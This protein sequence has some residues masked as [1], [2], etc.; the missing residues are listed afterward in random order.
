M[1]NRMASDAEV[2]WFGH[3]GD[4]NVHLNIL[5]PIDQPIESFKTACEPLGDAIMGVVQQFGGSVSAEHGVGLLK[6]RYLQYTRSSDEI[7][8]IKVLKQ[9]LDPLGV[10]NPG[11]I[12]DL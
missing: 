11:K 1:V 9:A 6:K 12:L 3:I 10:M 8:Q 5:K 2:I 4:G 7:D